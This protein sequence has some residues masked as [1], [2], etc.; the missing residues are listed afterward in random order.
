[1]VCGLIHLVAP[2]ARIMPLKAFKADGSANLSDIVRAVYYAVDNGARVINMSFSST[3]DSPTLDTAVS[4]AWSHNVICIASVGNAGKREIDYP[5]AD[6][7]VIGVGSTTALDR[8]SLFSDFG[9][10]VRMAAPGE[11][12]IT[13]YP[14][15]HYAGVWGTSFAAALTSGGAALLLKLAPNLASEYVSEALQHGKPLDID[16]MGDAR[17]D[18]YSSLQF[19]MHNH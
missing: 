6:R 15:N 17:L 7:A 4:Y 19:M 18:L 10:S 5:A 1:M 8:R 16:G 13:T 11:A 9:S 3:V 12:L 2:T 14:G